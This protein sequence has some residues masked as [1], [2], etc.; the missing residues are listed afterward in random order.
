MVKSLCPKRYSEV[1]GP[2]CSANMAYFIFLKKFTQQYRLIYLKMA[3]VWETECGACRSKG[4]EN[5][6]NS[7][8]R[9]QRT[10]QYNAVQFVSKIRTVTGQ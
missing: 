6:G 9:E 1:N 7:N 3:Y 2:V 8:Q 4:N 10:V 5:G